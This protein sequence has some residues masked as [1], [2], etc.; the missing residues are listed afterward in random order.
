MADHDRR[1]LVE[2]QIGNVSDEGMH[3]VVPH[4]P[5]QLELYVEGRKAHVREYRAEGQHGERVAHQLPHH[6][7]YT[8]FP[9]AEAEVQQQGAAYGPDE[10][11]GHPGARDVVVALEGVQ[12][13][14]EEVQREIQRPAQAR[15]QDQHPEILAVSGARNLEQ[16]DAAP[17][18]QQGGEGEHDG[19]DAEIDE[20]GADHAVYLV[21]LI[22]GTVF[23][24]ELGDRSIETQVE[25][26]EVLDQ[27]KYQHPNAVPFGAEFAR[28]VGRKQKADGDVQR[29][30]DPVPQYTGEKAVGARRF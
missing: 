20:P 5:D 8:Q 12:A 15:N 1:P 3:A 27:R 4:L 29:H 7:H 18:N 19:H 17:R 22:P 13:G 30:P 26:P 9:Q 6:H 24:H 21:G 2:Q 11:L 28:D 10:E 25:E 23:G 14:T 16:L